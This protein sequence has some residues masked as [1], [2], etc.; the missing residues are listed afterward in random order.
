MDAKL[1]KIL[2]NVFGLSIS[3]IEINLSKD[4]LYAWDSLRQIDLVLSLEQNYG[5][6]FEIQD[7]MRMTSV[8]NILK[9]LAEKEVLIGN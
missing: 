8:E 5:I 6:N 4:N 9:V 2:A 1:T 3:E 7:I